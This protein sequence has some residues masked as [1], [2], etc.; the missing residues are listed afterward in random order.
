MWLKLAYLTSWCVQ[1]QLSCMLLLRL[2]STIATQSMQ[3][4]HRRL[5]TSCNECSMLPL[6]WSVTHGSLIMAWRHSSVMSFIGWMCQR[7]LLT[8]WAY[9]CLQSQ[10]PRYLADNLITSSDVAS[11]FRLRS[12]NRHQL[13]VPHCR[14]DTYGRRRRRAFRSLVRRSGTHCLTN[15]RDPACGCDSFK[16]FLKTIL[17][18]LY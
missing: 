2:A 11:R 13:I 16:Q 3:G 15:S 14:L 5:P 10:A 18:S 1:R 8:R 17:F 7:R 4:H 6:V 12:A 9:W